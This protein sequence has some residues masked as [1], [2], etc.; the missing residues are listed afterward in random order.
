MN[1]AL[2]REILSLIEAPELREYLTELADILPYRSYAEI[3][4]GAPTNLWEKQSLLFRQHEVGAVC[5]GVR[6]A[7]EAL[8]HAP[9][10][11][12]RFPQ[13]VIIPMMPTFLFPWAISHLIAVSIRSSG[14]LTWL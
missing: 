6:A 1:D 13:A 3:I 4:A 9:N 11:L 14:Q 8:L 2:R 5:V 10:V 7:P 12:P